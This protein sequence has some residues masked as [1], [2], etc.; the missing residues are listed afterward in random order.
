MI[1]WVNVCHPT[2]AEEAARY[3]M[4]EWERV[5]RKLGDVVADMNAQRD[6]EVV[7]DRIAAQ[8]SSPAGW[9]DARR[10]LDMY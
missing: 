5:V 4:A 10:G 7:L 1:G 6:I 8:K 2:V 3:H 9:A